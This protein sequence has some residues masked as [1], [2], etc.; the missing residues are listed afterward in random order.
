MGEITRP[1][2]NLAVCTRSDLDKGI[3]VIDACLLGSPLLRNHVDMIWPLVQIM[4]GSLVTELHSL[5]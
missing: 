1:A 3:T 5:A 2:S 4:T